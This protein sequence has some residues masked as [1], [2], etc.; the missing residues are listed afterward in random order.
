VSVD[1]LCAVPAIWSTIRADAPVLAF[2][3]RFSP[4]GANGAGLQA[5]LRCRYVGCGRV[6]LDVLA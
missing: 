6:L 5:S 2:A 4:T 3:V 1:L